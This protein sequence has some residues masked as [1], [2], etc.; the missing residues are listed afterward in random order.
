MLSMFGKSVHLILIYTSCC[1]LST[2]SIQTSTVMSADS[3]T[4][5]QGNIH[6]TLQ[7][8][9][10]A[11]AGSTA[12]YVIDIV[13]LT[14]QA[15]KNVDIEVQLPEGFVVAGGAPQSKLSNNKPSWRID[16][17][18]PS[19][20]VRLLFEGI[21]GKSSQLSFQ[22]AAKISI[23]TEFLTVVSEPKL[24]FV[25]RGPKDV[26]IGEFFQCIA[27]LSNQGTL[28]IE[29]GGLELELTDGLEIRQTKSIGQEA[30]RLAPGESRDVLLEFEAIG[31]GP[32]VVAGVIKAD[33]GLDKSAELE[34]DVLSPDLVL[35]VNP[36]DL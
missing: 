11:V 1:F 16:E 19:V 14:Q 32:Q 22:V 5:V 4:Q 10:Q 8:P 36:Y 34:I 35:T 9:A 23:D 18:K 29:N 30:F 6:L 21:V 25:L 31:G 2:F 3:R 24:D 20:P 13:Q 27:V 15:I 26:V 7:G 17:L 33:G 12:R 28:S